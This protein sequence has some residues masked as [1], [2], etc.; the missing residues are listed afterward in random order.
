MKNRTTQLIAVFLLLMSA[1]FM[2]GVGVERESN[3]RE[4]QHK[5]DLCIE[6]QRGQLSERCAK[7]EYI[8]FKKLSK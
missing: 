8:T 5:R 6:Q 4:L 3:E 1:S 2:A 7:C